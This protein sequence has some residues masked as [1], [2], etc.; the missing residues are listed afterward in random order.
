V[1]KRRPTPLSGSSACSVKIDAGISAL[2]PVLGM[3]NL[4][5][6]C[7]SAG[8]AHGASQKKIT[9]DR[10]RCIEGLPDLNAFTELSFR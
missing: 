6:S 4:C 1:K 8:E 3:E 10:N 9:A 5:H 7:P 2:V